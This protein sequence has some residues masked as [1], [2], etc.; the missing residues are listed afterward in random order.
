M[1]KMSPG[2]R[3]PAPRSF[4]WSITA[5]VVNCMTPTKMGRPS[6][7]CAITSPLSLE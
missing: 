7:P 1:M 3:L 2:L 5:R 4:T 6:S